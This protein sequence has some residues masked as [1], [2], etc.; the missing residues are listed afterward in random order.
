ML[1]SGPASQMCER[2]AFLHFISLQNE[3]FKR[4]W[5]LGTCDVYFPRSQTV[6][7]DFAE[8]NDKKRTLSD[9]R[10]DADILRSNIQCFSF[11][12]TELIKIQCS[13]RLN[14]W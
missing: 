12:K 2:A 8:F 13:I 10:E 7:E 6:L 9:F 14:H 1:R 4:Y 3:Y 5:A 11:L